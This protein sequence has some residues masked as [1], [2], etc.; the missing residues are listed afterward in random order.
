MTRDP[1][2]RPKRIIV[3]HPSDEMYGADK[4]L[5]EALRTAPKDAKLEVWLPTDV[6]YPRR[7]LSA[8][9]SERGIVFRHLPLAILR[10]AYLRP[11]ELPRLFGRFLSS[12][13]LLIKMRPD[14]V[15]VNTAAAAPYLAAA[16]LVGARAVLHLHEYLSGGTKIVAPLLY[17]AHSIVAVSQAIVEPLPRRVKRRVK[18]VRNG[19]DIAR[20]Q[21]L[22]AFDGG[23][24]CVVASRWN[25]WKGHAVL[26]QAWDSVTRSDL[27]L[28][29]LGAAPE[30]GEATDVQAIVGRM[31]H[32]E[33]ITI[34]GQTNDTRSA[35]DRAHVV[36][37]PSVQP[38]PLPT[39]AIEA[40]AAGRCLIGS[41]LG[42]MPEISGD[43]GMLVRT[44]DVEA[45]REA[46]DNVTEE[47][48][49]TYAS[50]ARER[51]DSKFTRERFDDEI[52]GVLWTR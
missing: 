22:P 8:T 39:I 34:S 28:E 46:L 20:P 1:S 37:V 33:Q 6:D 23:I 50:R 51:F 45:W 49:R 41:D 32:G 43:A 48:V 47:T 14:L 11:K 9:L 42:G 21:E 35:L 44:G 25:A 5:L 2:G 4:V 13:R 52:Q 30:S 38:D 27:H 18:V 31:K 3:I 19:F 12:A 17:F 29:V 24:R 36:L 7:E 10:R 15:Y 26:L 40:L 16:R